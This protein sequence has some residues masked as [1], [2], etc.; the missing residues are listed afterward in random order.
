MGMMRTLDL[1]GRSRRQLKTMTYD[2]K[3]ITVLLVLTAN[4][5]IKQ[6]DRVLPNRPEQKFCWERPASRV[7]AEVGS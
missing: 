3:R 6:Q 2:C 7:S 1:F 4:G 5:A